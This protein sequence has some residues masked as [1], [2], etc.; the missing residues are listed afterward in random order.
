MAKR[1]ICNTCDTL[2]DFKHKCYKACTLCTNTPPCTND[3]TKYCGTCNRRF[4]NEKCFQNHLVLKAKGK[5]ICQWRQVCRNCSF[6]VASNN[7][8]ECF[9]KFCTNCNKLHPSGQFCY[10]APL[11]P[12][13]R[14]NKFCTFSLIRI[15][16]KTLR[17]V[18]GILSMF[19]TLYLHSRCSNVKPWT[20]EVLIVNSVVSVPTCFGR[21][22]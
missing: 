14:T 13:K 17:S 2:Y 4:F 21:A 15:V 1:S 22:L 6:L 12:S 11:K 19:L 7:K 5:L 10:L 16:Q 3:E 18:M 9:K 8:H 20:I